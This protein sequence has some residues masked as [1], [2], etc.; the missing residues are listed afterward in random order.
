MLSIG[1]LGGIGAGKSCVGKFLQQLGA[2]VINA[3]ALAHEAMK[4]SHIKQQMTQIWGNHLL[5]NGEIDRQ[6]LARFVFLANG[7]SIDRSELK[8][9]ED[10]L[11]PVVRQKIRDNLQ[12]LALTGT[13]AVVLDVPLLLERGL[14]KECDVLI[15]IDTPW[16]LRLQ[17]LEQNRH[18]SAQDLNMREQMQADLAEKR[19]IAHYV[20]DNGRS[21]EETQKQV[22]TI[23]NLLL[24]SGKILPNPQ[25]P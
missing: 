20:I 22:E 18:W 3:D 10:I 11:H 1:L 25:S 14:Y 6:A 15:F 16:H 24:A 5:V 17:R 21:L 9:L 13:A 23:W 8:K 12:R 2:A 7:N 19:A 4:E